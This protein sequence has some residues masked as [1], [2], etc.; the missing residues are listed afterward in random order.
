MN[1]LNPRSNLVL[2]WGFALHSS[3]FMRY[4]YH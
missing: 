4:N 2:D 1:C 3:F